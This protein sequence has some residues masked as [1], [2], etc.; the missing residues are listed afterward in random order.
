MEY[1]GPEATVWLV[2]ASVRATRSGCLFSASTLLPVKRVWGRFPWNCSLYRLVLVLS[3]SG[4][5]NHCRTEVESVVTH[6]ESYKAETK[7]DVVA[8]LVVK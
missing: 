6:V 7:N 2:A 8:A 4:S 5:L 3:W 1:R